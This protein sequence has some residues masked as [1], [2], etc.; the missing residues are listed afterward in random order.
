MKEKRWESSNQATRDYFDSMRLEMR[1]ID[2]KR[3]DTSFSLYGKIFQTPIMASFAP[4][5]SAAC[6][7]EMMK[8]A[9]GA[10]S[11]GAVIWTEVEDKEISSLL[12]A[13]VDNNI[14]IV[15]PYADNKLILEKIAYAEKC[16]ALGVG[17]DIGCAFDNDGEYRNL[18]GYDMAPKSMEEIREFASASSLPFVVKGILSEKDAYKSLKA[19]AKGIVVCDYHGI[20]D[21]AVSPLVVLPDILK[22]VGG[23]IP[24]FVD[25]G[26]SSGIDAFKILALGAAAVLT[27][28]FSG[29]EKENVFEMILQMNNQLK[30]VMAKTG[31]SD[32]AH[33]DFSVISL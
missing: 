32:L 31:C 20:V 25:C 30:G 22:T 26:I 33:I 27:D 17:I 18:L 3:P 5:Y 13:S 4:C 11:A 14:K 23:E 12:T 10:A 1:H 16:G 6:E 19:G 9:K 2:G 29:R 21:Y 28:F 7:N 8:L 24:V 15:K